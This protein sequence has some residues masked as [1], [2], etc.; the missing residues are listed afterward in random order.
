MLQV[1]DN[2]PYL[3]QTSSTGYC[4]DHFHAPG[5]LRKV[6]LS[7][8]VRVRDGDK[9]ALSRCCR[10]CDNSER[11]RATDGVTDGVTADVTADVTRGILARLF[12]LVT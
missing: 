4:Q 2:F 11:G 6:D 1:P 12:V 7:L 9:S 5:H 10:L 8:T 3:E